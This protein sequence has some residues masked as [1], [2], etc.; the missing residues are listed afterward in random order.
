[1]VL[2]NLV[3]TVMPMIRYR[4]GDIVT[5]SRQRCP[6]GLNL[7]SVKVSG[8][9]VADFVVTADGRWI[10][11]YAFI[12]IC[13][14]VSGII[15]FQVQQD[16]IG[17]VRVVVVTDDAFPPDGIERIRRAIRDRLRS[18]VEVTVVTTADIQ[19]APSGKY[20][21]VMSRVAEAQLAEAARDRLMA[22]AH[23]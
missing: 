15:K 14:S 18:D 13:R 19:P 12:Y 9:R 1:L 8:G 3:S 22:H 20:R 23:I 17:E 21:P 11:G 2:T 5:L 16:R 6:C 10:P 4:T 7:H